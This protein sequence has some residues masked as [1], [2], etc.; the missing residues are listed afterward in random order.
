L[1]QAVCTWCTR[2]SRRE[3]RVECTAPRLVGGRCG[4]QWILEESPSCPSCGS[5]DYLRVTPSLG[6]LPAVYAD[7]TLLLSDLVAIDPSP[8][9][10]DLVRRVALL[11]VKCLRTIPL[12][13]VVE[14][15]A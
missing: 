10:L 8:E 6:D 12:T 5:F 2:T 15:S 1:Q 7:L 3:T 14:R 11:Q 4:L 13:E 9:V